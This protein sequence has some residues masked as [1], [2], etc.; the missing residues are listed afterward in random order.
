MSVQRL[1][2]VVPAEGPEPDPI[3]PNH[4][5]RIVTRAI[6]SGSEQWNAGLAANVGALFDGLAAE[7]HTRDKPGRLSAVTDALDRGGPFTNGLAIELGS[8]T[9]FG[10][11][12]IKERLPEI[13]AVDL[14][15]E[16]L[17]RAP[18]VAP[19]VRA[20]GSRL[21][22]R[23]GAVANLLLVNMLLFPD[24]VER[25]VAPDGAVVW[26]NTSGPET[27]IYLEAEEV[28]TYLPGTWH[29]V[30]S[31]A[32]RGTWAVARRAGADASGT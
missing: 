15:M 17:L 5:M 6:A 2:R 31:E 11:A 7:W 3:D 21:P 12:T 26:V 1:P 10:T 30:A 28:D 29:V 25:V 23:D 9:G 16:M 22:F 20:D 19:R 4:P 14:S 13:V 8:G 27:P 18:G 24:E 32:G